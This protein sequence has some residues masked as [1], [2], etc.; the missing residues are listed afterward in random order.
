MWR[1]SEGSLL[2][3]PKNPVSG[4]EKRP[5]RVPKLAWVEEKEEGPGAAPAQET[6]KVVAFHP[7]QE[8]AALDLTQ[9]Q[10]STRGRFRRAAQLVCKFIRSIRQEGTLARGAGLK[11]YSEVLKH[12]SS[13][14]LLDLLVERGVFRAEQVP[15]MVRYIHQWLTAN[16]SAEHRLDNTLL[17]LT[18]AQPEDAVMTLLRVAPSCD[19]AAMAMWKTIMCSPRTAKVVQLILLD[20]LG[21]WPEYSTCTSDGD[22]TGVFALAATVVMW[23][24][25]QEPCVPHN[26]KLH[27]PRLFVRLLFQ[28]FFST[29]QMP[30]K[31]L[32][33]WKGCQEQ[34]GLA[35]SPNRFA[36]RTLRSLL[37]FLQ[38]EH[39]VMSMEC[40][41]GW[42]TLLCADTHHYAVGLLARELR[43]SSID[44]CPGI[45][46]Y[47]LRLLSK[48]M[49]YWDLPALAFLVEVLECL[50]LSECSDDVLEIMS[51]NLQ[52][53]CRERRRLALRGLT[54]LSKDPSMAKGMWS[55]TENLVELLEENDS[56]MVWMTTVLLRYLFLHNRAP[57]PSP[58]A[59]QLAEALLPLFDNDDSLVQLCSMSVFQNMLELLMEE[60]R[61]A[62]KSPV[63]QSLLP[64]S[65]HCHDENQ[66]VAEASRETL[67]SSARFL[68]RRDIEQ[69]LQVDQTWRFGEGLLAEDRSRAAEHLRRALPYLQSPQEPLREA[70]VR[71][72]GMAGRSLRGQQGELQLI[73]N[74]LEE[75]VNDSSP[76][77][78]NM[79]IETG[80]VIRAMQ[81]APYSTFR[82]L[83]DQFRSAWKRWPRLCSP[84]FL[85]CWIPVET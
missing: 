73:C 31:V 85:C 9:E 55:L 81:R 13:A 76:A 43:Q 30:K 66:H 62:L 27:F 33:F 34:H 60:G 54:V 14:A 25:L 75:M 17:H 45:A 12:E 28:V 68:K 61:K 58:M 72:M 77:I 23:K 22:K 82:R 38:C 26:V 41:R 15:A 46:F 36:V 4:M 52:R 44:F 79:A 70:A 39:V 48:E 83:R 64:L 16:D 3:V 57:I 5:P 1:F 47:L 71:F 74:A 29:E 10:E 11:E 59:L 37:C 18:K 40:K 42:D 51:K 53:E 56:D 8:D 80:F 32:T 35:T 50:D 78:R 19:R 24:I 63:R 2:Q 20:V 6:E 49:P 69:M 84:T 7:P 65:F 67:Y 21:S